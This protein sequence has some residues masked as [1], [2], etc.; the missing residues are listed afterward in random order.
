MSAETIVIYIDP[1]QLDAQKANNYNLFLAKLVNGQFT[2]IWQSLGPNASVNNPAYEYK[3]T[4]TIAVPSY[5]VNYGTVTE[6]QGSVTF[7]A[8]GLA[9]TITIGQ[10]TNLEATG[11]FSPAANDGAP[12]A[13]TIK[14]ELAANPHAI[15]LDNV[16]NPIFVDTDSGMDIGTTT[17]TPVDTYQIWFDSYQDTGTIIQHNVSNVATVTFSGG[18]TSLTYSY[19]ADGQW[20]SGPLNGSLSLGDGSSIDDPLS[21]TVLVA[22]KY[23]L[24]AASVV[25][26]TTKLINKFGNGLRPS[27]ISCSVGSYQA[28]IK[29][30]T[31]KNAKI[32][33]AFGTDVYETAVSMALTSAK[34]D[35]TSGLSNETWTLSEPTLAVSFL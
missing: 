12:G 11:L 8:A 1:A 16:G 5:E 31:K 20:V 33:G 4:F 15:L 21:V 32:L 34:K 29:F 13:I 28:K 3:N 30:S 2:V 10:S 22:F 27:E 23:A 26:L 14:N 6:E 35:P 19:N 17:L 18:E 7:S 24:T 25:Y 9:Q